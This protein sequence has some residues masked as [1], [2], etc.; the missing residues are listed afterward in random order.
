MFWCV[1]SKQFLILLTH[2][3]YLSYLNLLTT[4]VSN[5]LF[6]EFETHDYTI[7]IFNLWYLFES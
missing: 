1:Y 3:H 7:K 6:I 5:K 2:M 4:I